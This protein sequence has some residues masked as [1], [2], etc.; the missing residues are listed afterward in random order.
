MV[1]DRPNNNPI[2]WAIPG[3]FDSFDAIIAVAGLVP[4][5]EGEEGEAILSHEKGDRVQIGLPEHQVDRL[6]KLKATGHPLVVV[7]AGGSP[8]SIPEIH[9]I[10]DAII[11][12]WYPGEQG[13]AALARLIFGDVSPS[14]KLPVTF[15]KSVEQLPPFD[16]Y[17]MAG[18]TYRFMSEAPLYPFGFGLSYTSFSYSG[19]EAPDSLSAAD[20]EAGSLTRVT[21]T[22]T[23]EGH[24]ASAEV[25]QLYLR[26]PGSDPKRGLPFSALCAVSRAFIPAGKSVEVAFEVAA[27]AFAVVQEDGGRRFGPGPVELVAGSC[28]P[29]ERGIELGAPAPAVATIEVVA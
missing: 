17:K 1:P 9:E 7:L 18:R 2:D 10:A 6:K 11:Y 26:R 24:A 5:L 14:G 19:V 13:G 29:G 21:V 4:M 22:V 25:A 20:L 23:N 28:S 8:V 3:K 12:M 27:R 16:D 15:P